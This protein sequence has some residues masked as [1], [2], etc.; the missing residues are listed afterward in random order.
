M[1]IAA[2]QNTTTQFYSRN[3]LV[4]T[5]IHRR[6]ARASTRRRGAV[7]L[8]PRLLGTRS[9]AYGHVRALWACARRYQSAA[10]DRVAE[11]KG[12]V[13]GFVSCL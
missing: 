13:A 9:S 5:Y 8:S 12:P 2:K 1:R 11:W 3:Y 10:D 7:Q 6:R 4:G